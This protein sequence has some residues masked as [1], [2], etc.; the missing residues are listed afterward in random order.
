MQS[1]AKQQLIKR[2]IE[3]R[4]DLLRYAQ[5]LMKG[6]S[7][8]EDLVQETYL[9]AFKYL[10]TFDHKSNFIAWLLTILKNTFINE[11]RHKIFLSVQSI[12]NPMTYNIPDIDINIESSLHINEIKLLV[13]K[14]EPLRRT[15]FLL[16]LEGYLYREIAE[17]LGVP[18]GT[19]KS[20]VFLAR[21][22]LIKQIENG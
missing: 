1:K 16:Y 11:Y 12:D 7:G 15:S 6:K 13:H 2:A 21:Q 3:L 20:R 5:H 22:T 19:V 4:P 8:S 9:K 18:I 10:D 17:Q 14:L